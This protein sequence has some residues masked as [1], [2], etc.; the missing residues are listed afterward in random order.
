VKKVNEVTEAFTGTNVRARLRAL[1]A[2]IELVK[3]YLK[4]YEE[5]N[6]KLKKIM[7]EEL[8]NALILRFEKNEESIFRIEEAI[9]AVSFS[10]NERLSREIRKIKE[11]LFD[12]QLSK[13]ISKILEEK[14]IRVDSKPL[15]ELKKDYEI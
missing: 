6:K 13:S 12:E 8:I 7:S 3:N 1:Q 14:E 4:E 2:Q 5:T 9:E 11:D 10:L 15:D